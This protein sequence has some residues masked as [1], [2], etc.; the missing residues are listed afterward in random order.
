MSDI[1][2]F[3]DENG[4]TMDGD[5]ALRMIHLL[6]SKGWC[7][8]VGEDGDIITVHAPADDVNETLCDGD[9]DDAWFS[10]EE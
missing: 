6:A 8:K 4:H 10:V 5:M 9:I 1:M 2:L 3:F 7:Y